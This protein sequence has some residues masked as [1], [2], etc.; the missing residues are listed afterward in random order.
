MSKL[1]RNRA[2]WLLFFLAAGCEKEAGYNCLT[3]AG[4]VVSEIREAKWINCIE[5]HDNISL[6]LKCDSLQPGISVEA[7]ENLL[8]GIETSID[9]NKLILRNNNRCEWLRSFEVPVHVYVTVKNLD[10]LI[11]RSSGNVKCQN[12]LVNDSIQVDIWEGAGTLDLKVLS[13]KIFLY[14]HQGTADLKVSGT[15]GVTFLSS[16][17]LGPVDCLDLSSRLAYVY[18]LSPNDCYI[19]VIDVLDV[20]IE[21]IGNVYYKGNPFDIDVNLPG[22]GKL[23]KLE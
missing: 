14:I 7:G 2:L 5:V 20:T 23:I 4:D 17:G 18:T 8:D 16:K 15:S 1:F 21:N 12:Y 9:S 19:N 22:S 11:Y 13:D 3:P 10:T 6:I